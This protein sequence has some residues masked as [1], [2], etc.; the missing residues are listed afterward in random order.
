MVFHL[1][2]FP[3]SLSVRG[4]CMHAYTY[5]HADEWALT[6]GLS[7]RKPAFLIY[8]FGTERGFARPR[9][10]HGPSQSRGGRCVPSLLWS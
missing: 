9:Y 6:L 4:A 3:V 8:W 1:F 5:D 7:V 2:V 10:C